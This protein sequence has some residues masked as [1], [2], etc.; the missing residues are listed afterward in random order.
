MLGLSWLRTTAG[1]AGSSFG[2][3]A[4]VGSGLVRICAE[5]GVENPG[6]ARFCMG[7]AARLDASAVERR[8]LATLVFCDVAGSTALGERLDAEAVRG[9][10]LGY[11]A[12]AREVLE[13][14]GG[15]VE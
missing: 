1:P 13:R 11:F 12:E 6:A 14:H 8:K 3:M 4:S 7:C 9:L 5:C 15:T 10:M 2:A